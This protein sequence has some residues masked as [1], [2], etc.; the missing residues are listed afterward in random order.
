[1]TQFRCL[2]FEL[3]NAFIY[4]SI[5][6]ALLKR[7]AIIVENIKKKCI[8]QL[9]YK[10]SFLIQY[11]K[12]LMELAADA[13]FMGIIHK[14]ALQVDP[15]VI[16]PED[17]EDPAHLEFKRYYLYDIFV[18]EKLNENF[19]AFCRIYTSVRNGKQ[20]GLSAI[21]SIYYGIR[22]LTA[23][24]EHD[25]T[26][27]TEPSSDGESDLDFR[28]KWPAQYRCDDGHYVRSKNEQLVD[29]WLYHHKICHA[30]EVLVVDKYSGISYVSDFYL[31]HLDAYMEI[32][33]YET[34][35]YLAR[36]ARKREAYKNKG[37]KLIEMTNA[38][39]KVLDDYLLKTV[40]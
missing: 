9:L 28:K 5:V 38:E 34:S 3:H 13:S 2:V 19:P 25:S 35:E 16:F 31:P 7:G 1:M 17:T 26:V 27:A 36:K 10:E 20:T 6:I 37:L 14:I 15:K 29:N 32:W 39:I 11:E 40:L 12:E 30:Y 24:E 8:Q 33:G 22:Y 18:S 21:I 23:G 4:A